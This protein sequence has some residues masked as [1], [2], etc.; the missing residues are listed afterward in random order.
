[1]RGTETLGLRLPTYARDLTLAAPGIDRLNALLSATFGR[2][3][4]I[5]RR[6]HLAPWSVM[7]CALAG[8]PG[9]PSSVIVKWLRDDPSNF[10]V[11]LRQ[12]ATERAAL[13]FLAGIGFAHS[14]RLI[15]ADH[16]AG[17]LVLEDLAPRQPLDG[18]IRERGADA[19]AEALFAFA[20]AAGELGAVTAGRS[21]RYGA[22]RSRYGAT[23]PQ[24]GR[25][26]GLGPYWRDSRPLLEALGAPLSSAAKRDPAA[27]EEALLN[28]GQFLA[29]SNGDAWAGN[30]IT[31]GSDGR[32]IDFEFA[33]F[34]LAPVSAVWM[35]VPGP[36]WITVDPSRAAELEST[37]RRALAAGIAEADD[38]RLFGF[39]IAVAAL[40]EGC[41]RIGR[42]IVLDARPP[43]DTGRLQRVAALEAAAATAQQRGALPDL[44][45]WMADLAQWLRHRWPDTDVDLAALPAYT[46]R[47]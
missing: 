22:I 39:G 5:E 35:H 10:R 4:R 9:L 38:D 44:A 47:L 33:D 8:D 29:F 1:M 43:G 26:R 11:D 18:Q 41:D 2:P 13:E 7:R 23:D 6:E 14:P 25:E 32:L 21:A 36:A 24:A 20:R 31:S 17:V 34:R 12:V 40:A 37:Y 45:G 28:P 30:F 16:E 19:L 42:F 15:A 27:V 46:P 3:V